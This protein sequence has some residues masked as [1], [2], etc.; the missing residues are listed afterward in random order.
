METLPKWRFFF[1]P[2]RII[3][4]FQVWLYGRVVG[5]S[6]RYVSCIRFG[7][8]GRSSNVMC[9]LGNSYCIEILCRNFFRCMIIIDY[10]DA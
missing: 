5:Q 4:L 10:A 2:V 3:K 9:F 6:M 1:L 7:K 8:V